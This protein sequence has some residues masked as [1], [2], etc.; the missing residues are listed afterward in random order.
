MMIQVVAAYTSSKVNI[1]AYSMGS[2]IARK[3]LMGG[4]CAD[5]G[6][7]IGPPLTSLV[8][9]FVGVAGANHGSFLCFIPVGSC[10]PVN[11]MLCGSRFLTDIN[12][13]L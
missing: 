3:A 4:V 5:T 2:P 9:T 10:N 7:N 1:L 11:G 8:H 13:R 6:E 12:S